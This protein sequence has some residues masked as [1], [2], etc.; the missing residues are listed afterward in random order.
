MTL[1]VRPGY[2]AEGDSSFSNVSLLLH[3]NGTNGSTTIT[4]NSPTPKTVTAAGN[5]SIS[6]SQSKFGGSSISF[7]GNGDRLAVTSN[8]QLDLPGDFTIEAWV[9]QSTSP[10][11]FPAIFERGPLTTAFYGWQ[12]NNT[13]N[14]NGNL[15]FQYS[16]PKQY[17]D[18]GNLGTEQWAHIATTREGTSLK[19]FFNGT[20]IATATVSNNFTSTNNLI[21]GD[22]QSAGNLNPFKGFIDEFRITKGIARYTANFTPPD[23]P[24]PDAQY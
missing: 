5:A 12:L 23:A 10:P 2:L 1:I 3:G 19:T 13:L 17:V 24:F 6:T 21:I 11:S 14:T 20:L 15:S 4:D 8:A 16:S 7:D 9:Y 18:A 22:A